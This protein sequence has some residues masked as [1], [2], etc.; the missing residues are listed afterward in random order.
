MCGIAG[1]YG[2]KERSPRVDLVQAILV[3]QESRGPDLMAHR[4][5]TGRAATAVLGHNRLAIIDLSAA[6]DQPM[7]VMPDAPWIVY[8]G[9]IYNYLELREELVRA[10]ATFRSK[11]D[12]EVLLAA[13]ARRGL[14]ALSECNGMFAF[15]L[16]DNER[17]ELWLVRDRFGVKPLY[18]RATADELVFASFP[19]AIARQ[20]GLAPSLDF[21]AR[22][23]AVGIFDDDGEMS[24]YEGV[25][26]LRPGHALR[27]RVVAGRVEIEVKRWYDLDA[28]VR[29]LRDEL[30]GLSVPALIARTRETLAS[31]TALRLRSD[32]PVGLALSGGIDSSSLA[33]LAAVHGNLRG[34]TYG[35]ADE[36]LSEGPIVAEVARRAGLPMRY[37]P[38][39]SGK[40]LVDE[41]DDALA[42][43]DAPFFGYSVIAQ[44]AV[45]RAA[46]EDG[47]KVLLG[48]QG[49]DEVFMGYHK[50]RLFRARE[51]AAHGDWFGAAG[52]AW[53]GL[54]AVGASSFTLQAL[55]RGV[56]R[57]GFGERAVGRLRS[58]VRPGSVPAMGYRPTEPLWRRQARDVTAL[59]LPTLL[60]YEDRNSMAHGV[61]SRHPFMDYRVV[62]LGLA[63][64]ESVKLRDGVGKWILREA[65]ADGLIPQVKAA[66]GK[67]GFDSNPGYAVAAGLGQLVRERLAEVADPLAKVIGPITDIAETYSD[68][69]LARDQAVFT[70][71]VALIWLGQRLQAPRVPPSRRRVSHR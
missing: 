1:W 6:G 63:L 39:A 7:Q 9:E 64:P 57:Y 23:V 50:F 12:T 70:E 67:R 30:A 40:T 22:G 31:A 2:P 51:L 52:M 13:W 3:E 55:R 8:N 29:V 17:D 11:S 36:P 14:D 10:G 45:C 24:P 5:V 58:H 37:V 41:F 27:A 62:E 35:G 15:A 61:E 71:I 68:V 26:A 43:Q 18:Y 33:H 21:A 59:S 28:R 56:G 38:S 49:G 53:Q 19:G 54:R 69:R 47:V 32:V 60:R 25:T 44:F 42:A 4:V 65:M 66:R 48:G 16:F 34:F 20:Y 46:R